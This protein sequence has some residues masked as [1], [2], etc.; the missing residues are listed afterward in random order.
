MLI[1]SYVIKHINTNMN[2]ILH[3][4]FYVLFASYNTKKLKNYRICFR[5]HN[6]VYIYYL[7][8]YR[9]NLRFTFYES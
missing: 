7:R 1:F 5:I 6:E 3:K 9:M 8:K 4:L 2:K